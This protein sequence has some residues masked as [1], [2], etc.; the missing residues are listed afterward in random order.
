MKYLVVLL[1]SKC[2]S[3]GHQ[4]PLEKIQYQRRI[5]SLEVEND[6][7]GSLLEP[8]SMMDRATYTVIGRSIVV[9]LFSQGTVEHT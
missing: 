9:R 8:M 6:E 2:G 5:K 7:K 1:K 4:Y 3:T